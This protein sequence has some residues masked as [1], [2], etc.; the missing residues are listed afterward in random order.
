MHSIVATDVAKAK[1]YQK[2]DE[3]KFTIR[4]GNGDVHL[5]PAFQLIGT[6][7]WGDGTVGTYNSFERPR[8][9]Y[10]IEQGSWSDPIQVSYY[11]EFKDARGTDQYR[12][13]ELFNA[14]DNSNHATSLV[15]LSIDTKLP[16]SFFENALDPSKIGN[17]MYLFQG[18]SAGTIPIS[19]LESIPQN[20]FS[21]CTYVDPSIAAGFYG[22][23]INCKKITSSVP[24]LWLQFPDVD[25]RRCFRNCTR[26]ANYSSIPSNWR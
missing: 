6:V 25:G 4:Y 16:K 11:G 23:F 24:E 1:I 26:A 22:C 13:P 12:Q 14:N 18:N 10:H 17:F 5:S 21:E 19:D 7:H 9:V 2:K 20:L 8:H 3:F 15:I